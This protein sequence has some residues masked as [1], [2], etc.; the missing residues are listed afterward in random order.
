MVNHIITQSVI[1][2]I[3]VLVQIENLP[4]ATIAE[5]LGYSES[6]VADSYRRYLKKGY[7]SFRKDING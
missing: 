4:Y 5:R 7:E 1:R 3:V 2:K 6:A